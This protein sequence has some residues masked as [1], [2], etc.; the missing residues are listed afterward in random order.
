M[1]AIPTEYRGAVYRSKSEAMFAK[2]LENYQ[3]D[4][5]LRLG[6]VIGHGIVYEPKLLRLNGWVPDFLQWETFISKQ[7]PLPI[8]LTTVY[9]YK[10]ASPTQTYVEAFADKCVAMKKKLN[11]E[12]GR[13]SQLASFCLL[14]GSVYDERQGSIFVHVQNDDATIK[15]TDAP[16]LGEEMRKKLLYTRFDLEAE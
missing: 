4:F 1:Q 3:K 15:Y 9:E 12:L 10:P 7:F 16:W 2:Y 6:D 8:S 14:W 13:Q 11:H 5:V